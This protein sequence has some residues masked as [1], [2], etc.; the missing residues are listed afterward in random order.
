MISV[1]FGIKTTIKDTDV[2]FNINK[3][4]VCTQPIFCHPN[5]VVETTF[6]KSDD[7]NGEDNS[8]FGI[9]IN[10]ELQ[11]QLY[12][13][14]TINNIG[15]R[16]QVLWDF[17]DGTRIEGYNAKHAYTRPGKYRIS[18]VLFDIDRKGTQNQYYIDVIVKEIIPTMLS[19]DESLSSKSTIKCSKP[20]RIAR[21]QATLSNTVKDELQICARRVF[22]Y[23]LPEH[24]NTYEEIKDKEF[25]N[26]QKYYTFL[27]KQS[28]YYYNT[29]TVYCDDLKPVDK[30]TPKYEDI[31]GEFIITEDKNI[32]VNLY[33]F[34]KFKNS[35]KPKPIKM[36]SPSCE[37]T[38]NEQWEEI[39]VKPYYYDY[40]LNEDCSLF[41]KR[42]ITDIF[43][44][45]DYVSVQTKV[46]LFFNTEE[47]NFDRK[48]LTSV[49]YTNI[50]PLGMNFSVDTNKPSDIKVCL[51][52][53]GFIHKD[54]SVKW[55]DFNLQHI[56]DYCKH[57][58]YRNKKLPCVLIPYVPLTGEEFAIKGNEYY[59]PKDVDMKCNYKSN[60]DLGAGDNSIIEIVHSSLNQAGYLKYFILNLKDYI[61][62]EIKVYGTGNET[63]IFLNENFTKTGE[64][65]ILYDLDELTV[66]R[67]KMIEQNID[68][69]MECYFPHAMFKDTNV[70][71]SF[72]KAILSNN[73]ALNNI[74]TR[75][76]HFVD[77]NI[78]YKTS[79]LTKLLSLLTS[80]NED[81]KS[82]EFSD[83]DAVYELRDFV[84]L[85]SMNTSDL[86]GN[87]YSKQYD[88]YYD[89][90]YKGKN[91]GI[92]VR[93]DDDITIDKNGAVINV[94]R[95]E[96]E[97]NT[98]LV[99][100]DDHTKEAKIVNF[101]TFI[102]CEVENSNEIT[103]KIGENYNESWG[104]NLLLPDEY[105][106]LID[107]TPLTDEDIEEKKKIIDNHYSFYVL[108]DITDKKYIN[109]FIREDDILINSK[110]K[111]FYQKWI[112]KW[113]ISYDSIFKIIT[114]S[115]LLKHVGETAV[116]DDDSEKIFNVSNSK[117]AFFMSFNDYIEID[118]LKI[119]KEYVCCDENVKEQIIQ[120][121]NE[122]YSGVL[123]IDWGDGTTVK[124]EIKDG[125]NIENLLKHTYTP[126]N[127]REEYLIT[128]F[129]TEEIW[130]PIDKTI[131]N[132]GIE[133]DNT[134]NTK[135][136]IN[137]NLIAHSQNN[138]ASIDNRAY[139]E[140]EP[141]E[142]DKP[143][144]IYT[145]SIKPIEN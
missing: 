29:E 129:V 25:P 52:L 118:L 32:G 39:E 37:I 119:L 83:F 124:E 88:L 5:F 69:L 142:Q 114:N 102:K 133:V 130:K 56:E 44:K 27:E 48:L 78:N 104:W 20:E 12:T 66:P 10:G 137:Y 127:A 61:N 113:G 125:A 135:I 77:D 143:L 47:Q 53:N 68:V 42:A 75:S 98:Q 24:E 64:K 73:N 19:F 145:L 128:L 1:Q 60:D 144:T 81:I 103:L 51:T 4:N 82:Y 84:R 76:D 94:G 45:S 46:S 85:L 93:I 49:N 17:G 138:D 43:Y 70:M 34:L 79:Y 106:H 100:I 55:E 36:L 121:I 33:Q 139:L 74:L 96:Q 97:P 67:E 95:H 54:E 23:E 15:Y 134:E 90:T 71:K 92:K 38:K 123:Y 87:V 7:P 14:T 8:K 122:N 65:L 30:Y 126:S 2:L 11:T 26:L 86:I 80:L 40:E 117:M 89:D 13:E 35:E 136:S 110:D 109:N 141:G 28:D 22:Y 115:L 41:G 58:L 63:D 101:S 140:N 132:D 72:F 111:P 120:S 62:I 9:L 131:T 3:D 105:A 31:I 16:K 6:R 91:L 99:V 18:C 21:V 116:K 59:I 112:D 108:K 107:G 57:S 50:P